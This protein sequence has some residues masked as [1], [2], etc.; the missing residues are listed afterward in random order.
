MRIMEFRVTYQSIEIDRGMHL[1]NQEA[2]DPLTRLAR[3]LSRLL[4]VLLLA[5][6]VG[7]RDLFPWLL[8]RAKSFAVK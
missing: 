1:M 4:Q 8:R 6:R 3:Q 5:R 7:L 2:Y